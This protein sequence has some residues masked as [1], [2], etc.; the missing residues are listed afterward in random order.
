[1]FA[2][3]LARLLIVALGLLAV[4]EYLPGV[5]VDSFYTALIVAVI[6]GFINVLIRPVLLLLT[7][8]INI[9]TFG[10]FTFVINGL[11]LW[12]VA[13]FVEGFAIAGFLTAVLAALIIAAISWLGEKFIKKTR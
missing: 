5:D 12:F 1:M 4:A 11:L 8:P 13:S 7:L 10:L 2:S 6:L 9:V 3:F